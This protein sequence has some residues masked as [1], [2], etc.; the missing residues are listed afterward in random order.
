M[1]I[2]YK[3]LKDLIEIDL[4]PDELAKQLTLIGLEIDG[5]HDRKDDRIFDIEIT[6]NRGDCLSHYGVAREIAAFSG[7]NIEFT[8]QI[9]D[10]P[11]TDGN[12]LVTIE[13]PELCHR[14]TAR[15]IKGVK[16]GKS[17]E[18]LIDRLDAVGERSI[19]NVADI[20]NYVMHELG[21][22][23]HSFD[24]AKLAE[25]R[26]V[27]RTAK[28]GEKIKTLDEIERKLDKNTLLICDAEKPI[29]VGGVMGGFDSGITEETTDV[30]LEVAY[31]DRD[32]IRKTSRKL[33]LSTEASYHFERGVDIENL[34]RASN[35]AT[36]LICEIAGGTTGS[37][38]DTYPT[39][40]VPI[41][42][43]SPDLE[44]EIERLSGLTIENTEIIRILKALGIE[45]KNDTT[46]VAPSWRHD[47]AI[48][49][50]LVEEVVRIYGYDKIG[51]ELPRAISIGEYQPTEGR[52]KLLRSVLAGLGFDE[53]I[54]YSFIDA[55]FDY[56]FELLVNETNS[57]GDD[58]FVSI[59]DP[60]IEGSTRMR[61]SLLSGLLDAARINFNQQNRN[62]KLFE[63]GKVFADSS[64]GEGLPKEKELLSMI[65]TGNE[66]FEQT[67]SSSRRLDFYDL[68][69]ALEVGLS[70][71]NLPPLTYKSKNILHL[72]TGQSAEILLSE[73]RVGTIGKLNAS[74]TS[75]YKFKQP[76][77]VA[78]IDL[79]TLLSH[80][81]QPVRY[82]PLPIYP[83]ITRDVSLLVKGHLTYD[84][85]R[86]EIG[87]C[88]SELF[89]KVEFVD[90]FDGKGMKDGERSIT[91]RLE[92]RS[93]ERTLT[94]EEVEK[95][96]EEIITPLKT[97]LAIKQR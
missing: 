30:L 80:A 34:I 63:I 72:Q 5:M 47:L 67:K 32:N 88:D 85:I 7:K 96:H 37:F 92:Y 93:D 79:Q 83:S 35:R 22:P 60:I 84:D 81:Q 65:L 74:L 21:Q 10:E 57:G 14:F 6:S 19:N 12:E 91:I 17:P 4:T 78:E 94:E 62:V 97:T 70:A 45:Q 16:I 9:A 36:E 23:M 58:E 69:G 77:F 18:W 50:D 20:T 24:L 15:I 56:V 68:K 87:R 90:I 26:I 53:A 13:A 41:E 43:V 38:V 40:P 64:E 3:W 54:S 46:F 75:R 89:R 11:I 82:T 39:K 25:K 55:Q 31:F 44:S 42:I 8:S 49:E 71:L 76:V 51:E 52:K 48:E 61:P 95:V 73:G 2:S 29:A 33:D 59:K 66:T 1:I 27:V 28:E 86:T